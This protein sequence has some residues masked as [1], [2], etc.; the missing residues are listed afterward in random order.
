MLGSL[1]KFKLAQHYYQYIT[2]HYIITLSI[3]HKS[4]CSAQPKIFVI[5]DAFDIMQLDKSF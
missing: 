5:A 2:L 1:K 3:F 4:V